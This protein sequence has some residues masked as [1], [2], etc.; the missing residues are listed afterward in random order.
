[1]S[2]RAPESVDYHGEGETYRPDSC[3]PLKDAASRGEVDLHAWGRGSYPGTLLPS[4]A[5]RELRSIGVWDASRRQ[6]WGLAPHRNE[7][8]EFTYVSRGK[9]GFEAD[10]RKWSLK[11]GDLTI[12]RPWQLHQ[13]GDPDV[14]ASR[15]SWLI[16]DVDVRRPNQP[17]IWPD[18]IL[19]SPLDLAALT[20]LLRHNEQAVWSATREI[21]H[22]FAELDELVSTRE[23]EESTSRLRLYINELLLAMLDMLK[24]SSVELDSSLSSSFRTTEMFLAELPEQIQVNWTLDSMAAE[25]SLSR[26]QFAEYCKKITNM[27][28]IEYLTRC[29][30]DR[31][32]VMLLEFPG[33]TVT[34]IAF[35]CGFTSS[36]YF[37]TVFRSLQACSPSRHRKR[38]SVR[39]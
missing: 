3:E 29:R 14:G 30:V 35:E 19:L 6:R 21:A 36:Q 7:G 17:W 32:A 9:T 34:E 39:P 16:L 25:C 5:P 38:Q 33:A 37:S 27:T 4:S 28:P 1:M 31:A 12:T 18:W 20:R 15:V 10:G 26:S 22:C 11:R 2:A 24:G 8:I 13:V 23:A